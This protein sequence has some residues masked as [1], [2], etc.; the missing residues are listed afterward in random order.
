MSSS[1]GYNLIRD[2]YTDDPKEDDDL[3]HDPQHYTS[4][5]SVT[6]W[7]KLLLYNLLAASVGAT[8]MFLAIRGVYVPRSSGSTA[9]SLSASTTVSADIASPTLPLELVEDKIS[10]PNM[11]VGEILDCGWSPSE[12][13]AKGCVFDVMMQD[14]VPRPCFDEVLTERYLAKNNWTWYADA[15][16][17]TTMTDEVM[18][19]GDHGFAWMATSYHKTHCIFSWLKTIRALRNNRGISQELMS[20]DHV[21]HCAH[22]ALLAGEGDET[23]S[24]NAPTNYAKCALYDTWKLDFIPD[25]HDS[26]QR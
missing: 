11:K 26:T 20:Y 7:W 6:S 1:Q 5:S 12:A 22:G 15:D 24:V 13:R 25:K 14:W 9:N 10:A 21:L 2:K 8:A 3:K 16:G 18:R 17:N 4:T 23:L 19:K